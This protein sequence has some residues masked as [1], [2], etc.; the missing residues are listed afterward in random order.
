[1]SSACKHVRGPRRLTFVPSRTRAAEY[2]ALNPGCPGS[3]PGRRTKIIARL[4]ELADT[5]RSGRGA[6]THEGS[7]PLPGTTT[8]RF[9]RAPQA[10]I[11]SLFKSLF[12]GV[13]SSG[14]RAPGCDPGGHRFETDRTPPRKIR[15][16]PSWWNW[17]TRRAQTPGP[18]GIPARI[19][20]RAPHATEYA[21]LA[22]LGQSATFRRWRSGIRILNAAPPH[23]QDFEYW[24]LSSAGRARSLQD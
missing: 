17:Q 20:E 24:V 9:I 12:G 13:R 23:S 10:S 22:Q 11:D 19:R 7:R 8:R 6:E 2:R 15:C 18:S 4:V 1:M 16:T 21:A 3:S 14:G 5:P